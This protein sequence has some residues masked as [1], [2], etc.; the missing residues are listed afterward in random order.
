MSKDVIKLRILT[1]A[2]YPGLFGWALNVITYYHY[3]REDEGVLRD[4]QERE[5]RRRQRREQR[6]PSSKGLEE[7]KKDS[8]L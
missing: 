6:G 5:K 3:K 7:A 8:S 1:R 2:V 4:V